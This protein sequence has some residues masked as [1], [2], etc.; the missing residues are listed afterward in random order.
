MKTSSPTHPVM[1]K[2]DA[3]KLGFSFKLIKGCQRVQVTY[4]PKTMISTSPGRTHARVCTTIEEQP[5]YIDHRNRIWTVIK[6][7][8]R[9]R[10]AV[11]LG[12]LTAR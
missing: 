9:G 11:T 12:V 2:H 7:Y 10:H 6:L 3:E 4:P 1:S 5:Y 8:N